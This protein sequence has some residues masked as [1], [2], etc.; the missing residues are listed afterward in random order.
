MV[1]KRRKATRG[2]K[3][4]YNGTILN[5]EKLDAHCALRFSSD[6]PFIYSIKPVRIHQRS[7]KMVQ[8]TR[9]QNVRCQL[10]WL[11]CESLQEIFVFFRYWQ[12]HLIWRSAH[13][14]PQSLLLSSHLDRLKSQHIHKSQ[15]LPN[16]PLD[17]L[18]LNPSLSFVGLLYRLNKY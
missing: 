17:Q 14:S 7:E 9:I 2:P 12:H 8:R 10:Y 16:F 18:A 1:W 11:F 15:H 4:F 6:T 13:K 5:I 3:V